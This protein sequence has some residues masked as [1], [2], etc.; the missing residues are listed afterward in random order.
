MSAPNVNHS[1][2]FWLILESILNNN[3]WIWLTTP[4]AAECINGLQ[5]IAN[6]WLDDNYQLQNLTRALGEI[7]NNDR[8]NPTSFV[9][10]MQKTCLTC[11]SEANPGALQ[12]NLLIA[13]GD[14]ICH[15]WN[16]EDSNSANS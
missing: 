6:Q 13:L 8:V 7:P 2:E 9:E 1:K 3:N 4:F 5:S 14:T 12:I 16:E 15:W 10:L 11:E